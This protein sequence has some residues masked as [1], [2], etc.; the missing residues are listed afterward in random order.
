MPFLQVLL[1]LPLIFAG[2]LIKHVFYMK[3]GLGNARLKGLAKGFSKIF[4]NSDKRVRFGGEQLLHAC[5]MQLELWINCIR[6]L[7]G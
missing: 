5:H 1:N 2:I 7:I 6:I 3:K 4:K